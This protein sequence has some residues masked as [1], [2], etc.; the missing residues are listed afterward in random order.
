M[1]HVPKT[2]DNDIDLPHGVPT[3]GYETARDVGVDLVRN[4]MI[5]AKTTGRWYLVVS[6]GRKAGHL[7]LGIGKAVGATI[8]VIPEEFRPPRIRLS[9]IADIVVG[10]VIRRL[11]DGRRDGVAILAEGLVERLDPEDLEELATAER[12]EHGHIRLGEIQFEPIIKAAVV[13][14]LRE[15]GIGTPVTTK[16]IGY[17]LRCAAPIPADMEYTRDLGY[18]S[19]QFIINGG[20]AAVA[21]I[22]NG[23]FKPLYFEDMVDPKTGRTRVRMVDI[24]SEYYYIARRYMLRLHRSHFTDKTELAKLS[25]ECGLTPEQFTQRF[26]YLIDE[27][28]FYDLQR[29]AGKKKQ[30]VSDIKA[31]F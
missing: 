17:E 6:M 9:H 20:T 25:A 7:A 3:F 27:D 11:R 12:D 15:L 5:D 21:C 28:L 8:T 26:G 29:A 4:L 30:P 16:M 10:A 14:R 13:T 19:A 1:V 31:P 22:D 23:R 18:A 2:I 24:D